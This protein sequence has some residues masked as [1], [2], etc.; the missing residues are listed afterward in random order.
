MSVLLWVLRAAGAKVGGARRTG[1][2]VCVWWGVI[3]K[4]K[5]RGP[6]RYNAILS[7]IHQGTFPFPGMGLPGHPYHTQP[8]VGATYRGE[9]LGWCEG[10]GF[11]L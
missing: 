2:G 9:A 8:L 6:H 1:P 3:W 10:H 11:H 4:A 5:L 7:I